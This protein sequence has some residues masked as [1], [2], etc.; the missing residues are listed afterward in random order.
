MSLT[1]KG[2]KAQQLLLIEHFLY[3][4]HRIMCFIPILEVRKTVL[5]K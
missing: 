3:F 5:V 1:E 2:E 4:R